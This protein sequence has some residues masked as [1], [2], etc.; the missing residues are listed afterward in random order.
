MEKLLQEVKQTQKPGVYYRCLHCGS[1]AGKTQKKYC[2]HCLKVE[3]RRAGC[4]E[5]AEI[6]KA[7]GRETYHCKSCGI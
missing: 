3:D 7:N 6:W 4:E 2:Q 1:F 5:N